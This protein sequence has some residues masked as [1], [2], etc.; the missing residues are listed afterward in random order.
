MANLIKREVKE[1]RELKFRQGF[2]SSGRVMLAGKDAEQ[3][4]A[5]VLQAVENETLLH[6][7][8]AGSPFVNIKSEKKPSEKDLKEA[9]IFCARYSRDWKK[10]HGDVE[11]HVFLKKDVFKNKSM[12]EGTFGVKKFKKMLVKKKAL[13]DSEKIEKKNQVIKE[14]VE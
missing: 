6:T 10:N 12:K 7:K 5:V 4:E 9:V 8:A 11:V 14:A 3:N 2:T 1:S 13:Q